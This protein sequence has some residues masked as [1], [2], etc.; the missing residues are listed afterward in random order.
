[1]RRGVT[2]QVKELT[3]FTVPDVAITEPD[4]IF[5]ASMILGSIGEARECFSRT[6][7]EARLPEIAPSAEGLQPWLLQEYLITPRWAVEPVDWTLGAGQIIAGALDFGSTVGDFLNTVAP[8]RVLG[9]PLP[10]LSKE[11][12]EELSTWHPDLYDHEL[13]VL[14]RE[15]PAFGT[16]DV[17]LTEV[18]AL[19]L[20]Q[21]AGRLGVSL[22][23]THQRL[24]RMAPL[25]LCLAYAV[26]AVPEGIVHWRDLLALTVH[27]DGQKPELRGR[28]SADHFKRAAEATGESAEEVLKRVRVYAR[29]FSLNL[30][31]EHFDD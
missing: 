18:D 2:N 3:A 27:L 16:N 11:D 21:I 29:L 4:L 9:A 10:E 23:E 1:M 20:V 12:A 5:L 13:L 8:Y 6:Y 7:P 15:T 31:E 26:D 19:R 14:P 17:Y 24:T 28:V 22:Q 30:P 25:G